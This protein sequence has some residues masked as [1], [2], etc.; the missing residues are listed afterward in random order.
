[1]RKE[2]TI[3]AA[4]VS[5]SF[6]FTGRSVLIEQAPGYASFD[7]VPVISFDVPGGQFPALTRS[8][9]QNPQGKFNKIVV[10][11]TAAAA[12]DSLLLVSV[13]AC[14]D[15]FINF[16]SLATGRATLKPTFSAAMNDSVYTLSNLQIIDD[17][18][19]MPGAMYITA[20]GSDIAFSFDSDPGQGP[21]ATGHILKVKETTK[22]IGVNFISGFRAIAQT[23]AETPELSITLEY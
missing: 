3:P 21:D 11:G 17:S 23:A 1:M 13:D 19:R 9:Y 12:G 10:T 14:V 4:G 18:G 7:D 16:D 22:I 15:D 8:K 2:I 20:R 6:S 5:Q